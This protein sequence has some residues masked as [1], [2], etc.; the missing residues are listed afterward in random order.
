M[1]DLICTL[2][3]KKIKIQ[4][5]TFKLGKVTGRVLEGKDT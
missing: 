2:N 3:L 5:K 4:D 1:C